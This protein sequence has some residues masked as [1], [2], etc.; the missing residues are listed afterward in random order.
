MII[1]GKE[2]D[3]KEFRKQ[4]SFDP[5][6]TEGDSYRILDALESILNY[7]D[8]P[9]AMSCFASRD[10]LEKHRYFAKMV[11]KCVEEVA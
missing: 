10:D 5:T 7:A 2:I 3:L 11:R 6:G 1:Q 4:H 9:L 8:I